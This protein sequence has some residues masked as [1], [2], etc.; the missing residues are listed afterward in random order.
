MQ[1][2]TILL[3]ILGMFVAASW[4]APKPQIAITP[5]GY[6]AGYTA[7]ASPYLASPYRYYS[8]YRYAYP[9]YGYYGYPYA[10]V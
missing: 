3:V 1:K 9:G 8:P 7:Y 4:A 5:F 2:L 6:T 10:V